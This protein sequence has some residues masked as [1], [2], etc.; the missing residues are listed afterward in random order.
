MRSIEENQPRVERVD[1]I[2]VVYGMLERIG[3]QEIIDDAVTPHANWQGLSPG[4][5]TTLWLVHIL[6]E[7][8]HL[9]EPVQQWVGRQRTILRKLSGQPVRERDFTDDRLAMCLRDL[10]PKMTWQAIEKR[11]GLRM[12]RVYDLNT[13]VIRLDATV[14]T[15]HHEMKK[16]SLFPGRS[17]EYLVQ[18]KIDSTAYSGRTSSTRCSEGYGVLRIIY[19]LRV[20]ICKLT[21]T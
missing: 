20:A 12:I 13:D 17:L 11:L 18:S 19:P 8:N 7:Q 5:V 1:D 15:V 2:P 9:M 4:W 16:P 3:I 10:S 6:S 14:G 21:I